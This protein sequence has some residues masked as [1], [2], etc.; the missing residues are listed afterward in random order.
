MSSQKYIPK[1]TRNV[2]NKKIDENL[3]VLKNTRFFPQEKNAGEF[4][5]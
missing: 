1:L 2:Y 5:I 4:S 3:L